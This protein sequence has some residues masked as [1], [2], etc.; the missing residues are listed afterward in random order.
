[1]RFLPNNSSCPCPAPSTGAAR[2]GGGGGALSPPP[3]TPGR[4][5][6]GLV[7]AD[8]AGAPGG[9]SSLSSLVS[10][11]ES[12][13]VAQLPS[14]L[15]LLPRRL[16]KA[17]LPE[18]LAGALWRSVFTAPVAAPCSSTTSV[19]GWE[20]AGSTVRSIRAM[21]WFSSSATWFSWLVSLTVRS[22]RAMFWFSSSAIWFRV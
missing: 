2:R 22:I 9:V 18:G 3:P 17:A 14:L 21:F 8:G 19:C 13:F 6:V 11:L 1:M 7:G 16:A 10:P 12:P 4:A 15:L 5:S 20:S